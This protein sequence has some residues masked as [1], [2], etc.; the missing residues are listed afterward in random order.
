MINAISPIDGRYW[1]KTKELSKYFSEEGLFKYRL[2]IEIRYLLSLSKINVFKISA[3]QKNSLESIVKGFSDDDIM[4]IK[5]YE[6]KTHHDIKALEYFIKEKTKNI[7]EDKLEFIHFALTSDD[8]NN[9]AYALSINDFIKDYLIPIIDNLL[10]LLKEKS[11]HWQSM[12]MI[13]RT[14]GQPAVPTT[15][16]KEMSIF[17]KRIKEEKNIIQISKI[18]GKLNGAVG[19]FNA[20]QFAFPKIDWIKFSEEFI[21]DLGLTPNLVTTQIEGYDSLV[22]IFDSV[23]RLNNILIGFCQ[24]IWYYISIDYLL[25]AVNKEEVGSSTMP[26]KVNPIDFE[27]AE[28]NLGLAN[29]L[30]EFFSRKLQISRLQRDLTDSTV[31]RNFGTAFSISYLSYSSL[32]KGLSKISPNEEILSEEL[33]NNWTIVSEGI[34][35]ILRANKVEKPYE[36]LKAL[37]RGKNISEKDLIKFI[38]DLKIDI[39]LKNRMKKLTPSTYIGLAQKLTKLA[40]V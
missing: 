32:I 19:N 11:M 28:G 29:S 25:Q 20:H 13:A 7:L 22:R 31:R 35:T 38:D 21:R 30:F 17:Y 4:S 27:L 5:E 34:Q 39:E 36:K 37:T 23:K 26:Q 3:S 6:S 24:D 33:N 2:L 8:I 40:L 1:E 14:H 10:L 12:P 15:L 18:S 9:L 16:G